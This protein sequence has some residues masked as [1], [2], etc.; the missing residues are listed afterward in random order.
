MRMFRQIC[1]AAMMALP[2]A[3]FGHAKLLSTTPAA[4]AQVSTPKTLTLSFN[5]PVRLAVLKLSSGGKDIPLTLDRGAPGA[6]QVS[7]PLPAL[8]AGTYQVEWS[9]LT[10]D[11]GHVVK[12][13]F[14]FTVANPG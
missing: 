3:A 14:S 1:V 9:A 5:E 6:A 7:V 13:T 12:G 8:G 4:N 11:D 2:L 10:V